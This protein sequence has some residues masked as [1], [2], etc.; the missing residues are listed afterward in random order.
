MKANEI[1]EHLKDEYNIFVCPNGGD[2]RDTLFR[3]GHMGSIS[4]VDND[5]LVS[6]FLICNGRESCRMRALILR[7]AGELESVGIYR[8]NQSVR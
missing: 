5:K 4:F 3:V 7:Q 2:L 1:F 6:A 8:E